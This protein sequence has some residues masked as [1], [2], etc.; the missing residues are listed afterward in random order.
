MA[1]ELEPNATHKDLFASSAMT[2]DLNVGEFVNKFHDKLSNPFGNQFIN[3]DFLYTTLER[4]E[5][6]SSDQVKKLNDN[7]LIL[8][9]WPDIALYDD[10]ALADLELVDGKFPER[11]YLHI[12]SHLK[13][14]SVAEEQKHFA[15]RGEGYLENYGWHDEPPEWREARAVVPTLPAAP[16]A[17]PHRPP[18]A[19]ASDILRT[20]CARYAQLNPDYKQ[21]VIIGGGKK[22]KKIRKKPKKKSRKP[23]RKTKANKRRKRTRTR[24]R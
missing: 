16:A 9:D 7:Q 12:L 23:K 11:N 3:K 20:A 24:R 22:S 19:S 6:L 2:L 14:A 21:P 13:Q 18:P 17:H 8:R 10:S 1:V 15:H 5:I 4:E